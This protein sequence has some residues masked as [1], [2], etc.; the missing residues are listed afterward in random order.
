MRHQHKGRSFG[1]SH[2]QRTALMRGLVKSLIL[3][4]RI[5]TTEAK[6]RELRPI[7]EKLITTSR[8]DSVANRRLVSARLGNDDDAVKKLFAD[9]APRYLER[10]GG[11][12]RITKRA[13]TAAT[14]ARKNAYISLV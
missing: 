12:T 3:H 10:A 4:E 11:Y 7:I 5:S 2:D 14:N 6:A 1:R 9:I 13:V 8:V